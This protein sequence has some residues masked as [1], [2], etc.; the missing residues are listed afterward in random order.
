MFV[1]MH[2]V[3]LG[4]ALLALL[5]LINNFLIF[6]MGAPGV[7]NTVGL[8][9]FFGTE[10]AKGGYTTPLIV[11][12]FNGS[13]NNLVFILEAFNLASSSLAATSDPVAATR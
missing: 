9:E 5:F 3:G 1:F 12:G 8:T 11:V 6:V 13:F 2:F 7:I 4:S 10:I